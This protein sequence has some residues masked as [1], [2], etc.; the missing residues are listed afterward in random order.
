MK[1]IGIFSKFSITGGSELRCVELANAICQFTE[2]NAWLLGEGNIASR[3]RNYINPKVKVFPNMFLPEPKNTERFYDL[4]CLI[5]VNTDS[6]RFTTKNYW[7]GKSDKHKVHV[8]LTKI[9][10]M[11]FIFNYLI[12]PA[13]KLTEIE[14]YCP[15]VKIITT[16]SKFFKEIA[17]KQEEVVHIPRIILESPINKE[18]ISQTKTPSYILRVGMHSKPQGDK[19]NEEWPLL[20]K[21]VNDQIGEDNIAWRF[22][23]GSDKFKDSIKDIKNTE[24]NKEFSLSVKDF[25]SNLDVFAFF[26]SYKR[27]E[28]WSRA[29]AEGLMSGC[30]VI[31]L[32]K[33][34]NV[35]QIIHGNNGFLCK[36]INDFALYITVLC[37]DRSLLNHM[38]KNC[39][40]RA[41]TFSSEQIINRF[42]D[43]ME[44]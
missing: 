11:I 15:N 10:Q 29:V 2:H 40:V 43:F 17:E 7:A 20:I 12:S 35:D 41:E 6:T 3:L 18:T 14:M 9:K 21:A 8:D 42:L 36:D 4:D 16:N 39:L 25:L 27:E 28:P 24:F 37:E 5:I 26:T 33:G 30:P 19:W 22:M 1:N 34:G 32:N 23:G 38:R 13:K 31:A 44:W